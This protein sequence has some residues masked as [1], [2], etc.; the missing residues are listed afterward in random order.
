MRCDPNTGFLSESPRNRTLPIT[1]YTWTKVVERMAVCSELLR[2]TTHTM[3]HLRLTDLARAG[4]DMQH[5]AALA[6]HR[7]LQSTL[8]YIHLSAH[9]LTEALARTVG[10]LPALRH[11]L[12]GTEDLCLSCTTMRV[13]PSARRKP[14]RP[15]TGV[16]GAVAGTPR[17]RGCGRLTAPASLWPSCPSSGTVEGLSS[18]DGGAAVAALPATSSGGGDARDRNRVL[19]LEGGGL[20]QCVP[21]FQR[22][23]DDGKHPAACACHAALLCAVDLPGLRNQDR[24]ILRR[25]SLANKIFGPEAVDRSIGRVHAELK[26]LGYTG[27][28]HLE[29]Q[30]ALCELFLVNGS[31][32]L[33]ALTTRSL[34]HLR[35]QECAYGLK[36]ATF[37]L[38]HAFVALSIL[39]VPLTPNV[40]SKA[41][42]CV[43]F[44]SIDPEWLS[45]CTRWYETSTLRP[46]TNR[47]V[48]CR[49]RVVGRCLKSKHPEV[50]RPDQWTRQLA[51]EYVAAT[52]VLRVGEFVDDHQRSYPDR[53]LSISSRLGHLS[54]LRCFFT[55]LLLWELVPRRFDP[56]LTLRSSRSLALLR[57][58]NP[59]HH[60]RRC[61]GQTP[62]GWPEPG[63]GRSAAQQKRLGSG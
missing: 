12:L 6:G 31:A 38:S 47:S 21:S 26:C 24:R 44:T 37:M 2:L 61:L 34:E 14:L 18:P 57:S 35:N 36:Q 5:I 56:R 8:I 1:S 62:L 23:A 52:G 32:E 49:L 28:F 33:T 3:R 46:S 59:A 30:N 25:R 53:L 50:S 63:A 42:R 29:V 22:G 51:A 58:P 17:R 20:D 10:S 4:L 45:W 9:D 54:S 11:P 55:D 39:S 48:R 41:R 40:S 15:H 27:Y 60:R 7:V 13:P 19:G 43:D 16:H